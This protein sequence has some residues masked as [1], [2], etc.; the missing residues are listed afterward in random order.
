M[1]KLIMA[2]KGLRPPSNDL[3]VW[4]GC[5]RLKAQYIELGLDSNLK[6]LGS[7][8]AAISWPKLNQIV[9]QTQTNPNKKMIGLGSS[10][11]SVD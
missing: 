9:H 3:K 1:D 10:W 7:F 6:F 11:V 2:D 8:I 4:E 5:V